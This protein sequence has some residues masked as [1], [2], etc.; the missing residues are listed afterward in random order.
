M[1]QLEPWGSTDIQILSRDAEGFLKDRI[2]W[3]Q[4]W[5]DLL[6]SGWYAMAARLKNVSTIRV[7]EYTDVI[8]ANQSI[9]EKIFF[10]NTPPSGATLTIG[11]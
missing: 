7:P 4:N 10:L 1:D 3:D 11:D 8:P 9:V 2:A 6:G 5:A